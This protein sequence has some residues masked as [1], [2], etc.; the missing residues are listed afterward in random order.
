[1]ENVYTSLAP[2]EIRLVKIHP[3]SDNDVIQCTVF[4]VEW[5]LAPEYSAISYVWGHR[6]NKTKITLNGI[7]WEVT[8]NLGAALLRLRPKFGELIVWIDA[9]AINQSDI[10]ERNKQVSKMRDIY[11]SASKVIIWL[12][13][14][15]NALIS[16]VFNQVQT[17]SV[18]ENDS[19]S[20]TESIRQLDGNSLLEKLTAIMDLDYWKRVWV[21]QEIMFARRAVICYGEHRINYSSLLSF[22]STAN[23]IHFQASHEPG[24]TFSE[25]LQ[26]IRVKNGGPKRMPLP[27]SASN[28]NFLT[29]DQW[30]SNMKIRESTDPRDKVFGFWGC[31][32]PSVRQLI[33]IDYSRDIAD[34]LIDM[35]LVRLKSGSRLDIIINQPLDYV[36]SLPSW[37]ENFDGIVLGSRPIVVLSSVHSF[38]ASGTQEQFYAFSER[39]LHTRG[40]IIG[41]VEKS[42]TPAI[43][44]PLV[45]PPVRLQNRSELDRWTLSTDLWPMLRNHF[46]QRVEALDLGSEENLPDDFKIAFLLGGWRI[47]ADYVDDFI[48]DLQ[49]TEQSDEWNTAI[50]RLIGLTHHLRQMISFRKTIDDETL[51]YALASNFPQPGDKICILLGCSVPVLLRPVRNQYEVVGDVFVPHY[52]YGKGVEGITAGTQSLV[53]FWIQ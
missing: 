43:Y 25:S 33:N 2:T 23:A 36:P 11:S 38:Q 10:E 19:T 48:D 46:L 1:M 7:P 16:S 13:D 18:H 49:Y 4:K 3:G 35:M 15:E 53:D 12:G 8:Q 26:R 31:F 45:H 24:K 22:W 40:V 29:L 44:L 51:S 21:V 39:V 6:R 41:S 34:I 28:G 42:T 30:S 37:V 50:L 20:W 17:L 52:M 9:L 32:E 14:S 47:P 5:E 27:G